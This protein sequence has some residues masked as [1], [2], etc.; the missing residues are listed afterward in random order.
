MPFTS[1]TT[2][3]VSRSGKPHQT[4]RKTRSRGF[5]ALSFSTVQRLPRSVLVTCLS[6]TKAVDDRRVGRRFVVVQLAFR[7]PLLIS[8][9]DVIR[10]TS[11]DQKRRRSRF[12]EATR[13]R[14]MAIPRSSRSSHRSTLTA[15]RMLKEVTLVDSRATKCRNLSPMLHS[16]FRSGR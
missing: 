10:K 3:R 9:L 14:L 12:C 13:Q 8:T 4:F 2:R 15:P 11:R 1:T 6:S 5:Q 7:V 16:L